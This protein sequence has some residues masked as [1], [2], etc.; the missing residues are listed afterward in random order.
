MNT[1]EFLRALWTVEHALESKTHLKDEFLDATDSIALEASV[2]SEESLEQL[3][4]SLARVVQF[5]FGNS[6]E[7]A[8]TL[9][10]DFFGMNYSSV[11]SSLES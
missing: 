3:K 11:V 9:F 4:T 5:Y 8:I 10:N 2:A 7:V 6:N 1:A